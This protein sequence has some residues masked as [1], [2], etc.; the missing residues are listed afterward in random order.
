MEDSL[1]VMDEEWDHLIVLDGCRYDYF[2]M[3]HGDYIDG[4][5]E[6]AISVGSNTMEWRDNSFP[7][8]YGDVV[9]VSANPYI[10]SRVEV[11][12]FN[13]S[14][15]FLDVIDVW[16][17]GWN[18][19]LGTVHPDAVNRAAREA[20]MKYPGE[21]LII[22]YLQPHCP[23]IGLQ[24]ENTGF[25]VQAPGVRTVLDG[26]KVL[27]RSSVRE[28]V[29]DIIIALTRG[30]PLGNLEAVNEG[31]L[32]MLRERLGLPPETPM[33][34][35]R[36]SIG[37]EGLRRAY[38]ENLVL[39]LTRLSVL[40][41]SLQGRVVVTADHGELLGEGGRFSH[42]HGRREKL[43]IEVPWFIVKRSSSEMRPR[44]RLKPSTPTKFL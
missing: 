7:D 39:V 24:P 30:S 29:V 4:K 43:L 40:L 31:H 20:L 17:W 15:H 9:Y 16:D 14:Q 41:S 6:K 23:Y 28:K 8:R 37:V 21:R 12:G 36:R 26:T 1:R 34:S 38:A 3:L 44:G 10:N 32:W 35:V 13:G 27:R 18:P 42:G 25:P 2:S 5:L 11:R 33:D 22:H 19:T